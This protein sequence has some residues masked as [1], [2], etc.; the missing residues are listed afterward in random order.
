MTTD[1]GDRLFKC[2]GNSKV[3]FEKSVPTSLP[4]FKNSALRQRLSLTGQNKFIFLNEVCFDQLKQK[5]IC[6][7]LA[8]QK[9]E[10]FKGEFKE[11]RFR[12]DIRGSSLP[13]E[14]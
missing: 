8:K 12:L 2:T 9:R 6:D 7:A 5:Y 11:G 1:S 4:F 3:T 14:W 13:R 10:E